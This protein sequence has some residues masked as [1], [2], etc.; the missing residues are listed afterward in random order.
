MKRTGFKKLTYEEVLAKKI[1]K[2]ATRLKHPPQRAT[3]LTTGYKPRKATTSRKITNKGYKPP[4][5]FRSIP[6]GSHG[7]NPTQKRYWKVV[8]NLVRQRDFK[9][10]HG[11]CVSCN[12]RLERWEDGQAAHWKAWSVCNSYSKYE[13]LNLALSCSN[14]NRLSDGQ[15]GTLFGKELQRRYGVNVLTLIEEGSNKL[16]GVK[17]QDYEIVAR[18]EKLLEENPWFVLP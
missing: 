4:D 15:I 14:C 2:D 17:M 8:S 5:W 6:L 16:R 10:Y 11:K 13:L 12:A 1:A 9:K 7:S 3:S 18:V